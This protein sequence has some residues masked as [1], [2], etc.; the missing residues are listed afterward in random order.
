M[1]Y[2]TIRL[3][4]N[5]FMSVLYDGVTDVITDNH[6]SYRKFNFNEFVANFLPDNMGMIIFDLRGC[7]GC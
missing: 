3:T 5:F 4:K 2:R 6:T 1:K 7:E